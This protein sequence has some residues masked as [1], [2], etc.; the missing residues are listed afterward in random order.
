MESMHGALFDGECGE[1]VGRIYVKQSMW[2]V[3]NRSFLGNSV[4][5]F[6]FGQGFL[7]CYGYKEVITHEDP[8][9]IV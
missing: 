3:F 6:F 7:V 1:I 2:V 5:T 8:F 4:S 9:D